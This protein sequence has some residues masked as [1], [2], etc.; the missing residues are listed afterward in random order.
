MANSSITSNFP[1]AHSI[2]LLPTGK[3]Y[4]VVV[5]ASCLPTFFF[6]CTQ[7]SFYFQFGVAHNSCGIHISHARKNGVISPA[8]KTSHDIS[9]VLPMAPS[10]QT[11]IFSPFSVCQT[12]HQCLICG[13]SYRQG[14][15]FI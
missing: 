15:D 12:L 6:I 10:K 5:K 8:S 2:N 1:E 9:P 11:D 4:M 7:F 14:K 3:K 13:R